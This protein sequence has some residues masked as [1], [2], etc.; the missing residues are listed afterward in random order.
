[1]SGSIS[2]PLTPVGVASGTGELLTRGYRATVLAPGVEVC[3]DPI[4]FVPSS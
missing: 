3:N 1:V 4:I 2:L